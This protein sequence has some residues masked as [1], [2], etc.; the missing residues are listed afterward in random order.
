[1][2]RLIEPVISRTIGKTV[3]DDIRRM[4]A[5]V[6]ASR[7]DWTIVRPSGPVRPSHSDKLC[8]RRR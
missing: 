7:L 1:M 8:V 2:L 6:R 4:E 5:I 3:Y